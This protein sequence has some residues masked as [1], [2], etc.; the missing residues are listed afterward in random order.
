MPLLTDLTGY[1]D[2]HRHW[3]NDKLWELFDGT[4]ERLNIT[5]ECLGRHPRERI[6]VRVAHSD[7]RDE[8]FTFGSLADDAARFACWLSRAGHEPGDRIA[9]MLEPSRPFYAA[10]F[11]V[12][13]AGCVAVPL[14][15]LFG[16]D[17]FRLRI[18]DCAPTLVVTNAD[19]APMAR[20]ASS[21]PVIVAD[22]AFME[23]LP[24]PQSTPGIEIGT[25]TCAD[26]MAMYQYTSGT[27]RELPDAVKHRHRALVT[28]MGA[29]LYG[30]GVR[31]G[32]RFMCPSSPA[33]GHGL[34]H[35]TLAPLAMGVTIAAYSGPFDPD[36]LM[37]ALQDF[38]I[39]NISV[40]ATHLRMM[41]NSGRAGEYRINL[42]KLTFTGEPIDSHTT[43]WAERI[44]RTPVCSMYGTTEVGVIL[45]N[46]PG[47]SDYTVRS[48]AL[49]KPLPGQ[50]VAVLD[51][52]GRR[53]KPGETGQ[54]MVRR[55]KRWIPTRDRGHMDSDGYFFHGGRMDDAII[56]AGWTMSAVEI[57]E[58]LLK[59]PDVREAAV[60]GVPDP[61][62]GQV[63]KAFI[64]S[65][66]L[67]DQDF[68]REIQA[69]TQE[70]L[71]RHEYPRRVAFT[72]T[73]P[74]NPAGK[75]NRQALRDQESPH[76]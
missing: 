58:V 68:V 15:T 9:I 75:V 14:F 40:A 30:T 21:V 61:E 27:T 48:G 41:K 71:S 56:S 60:I 26:D 31:P 53:C 13:Q 17:G 52:Q 59:H 64:V 11:G 42:D 19:K 35:G 10:L 36:R 54:I 39:T 2:A 25:E 43:E 69:F 5:H 74:K 32:D 63:V 3:H 33:W 34:W 67:G 72:D 28:V 45:A 65:E 8:A 20:K 46:Y 6:A 37:Q 29:A 16:P 7:G 51:P 73:L 12:M 18:D 50:D 47:A 4:R 62:R 55:G 44:F 76:S 24:A 22:E 57:E 70:R 1:A 38:K 23:A 66:R 49:G